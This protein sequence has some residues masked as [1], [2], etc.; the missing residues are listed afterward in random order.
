MWIAVPPERRQQKTMS[1]KEQAGEIV[2][3]L[4][5][6]QFGARAVSQLQQRSASAAIVVID[7]TPG[8]TLPAEI[9]LITEDGIHWLTKHFTQTARVDKIIPALPL[10][11][12]AEWLVR[13]LAATN[14]YVEMVDL[15]IGMFPG[16]LHPMRLSP[17][18]IALSYADFLCPEDCPEPK[19][20]C[21]HTGLPR[22]AP[23]YSL[24]ESLTY[25]NLTP[26]VLRSRQFAPGVGGFYPDDL[27]QF[28]ERVKQHSGTPLLIGTACKCHGIVDGILLMDL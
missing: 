19:N 15:Q 13:A 17:S 23:M 14:N 4:G 20:L 10:H 9:E 21:T 3:I 11:M 6:G 24:L 1:S 22:Q 12:L 8:N 28:L 5:G 16:E 2:W 7:P 25:E 18:Q 26:L 27:W